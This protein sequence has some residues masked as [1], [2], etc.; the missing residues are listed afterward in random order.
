[1][2]FLRRFI[3]KKSREEAQRSVLPFLS[4]TLS[5][6]TNFK[7]AKYDQLTGTARLPSGET[8]EVEAIGSPSKYTALQV[9]GKVGVVFSDAPIQTHISSSTRKAYVALNVN[10]SIKIRYLGGT[11][12]FDVPVTIPENA[13]EVQ[14]YFSS[15]C[16]HFMVGY[17]E[18][19]NTAPYHSTATYVIFSN[20][21]CNKVSGLFSYTG[22]QQQTYQLNDL[23]NGVLQCPGFGDTF[24]EYIWFNHLPDSGAVGD[25][26]RF[27]PIINSYYDTV[28][29]P[30]EW[31]FYPECPRSFTVTDMAQNGT[32]T[33]SW[34]LDEN[35][36]ADFKSVRFSFNNNASGD[37]V[38]DIVTSF[39]ACT[40]GMMLEQEHTD[41]QDYNSTSSIVY[42][43]DCSKKAGD[44]IYDTTCTNYRKNTFSYSYSYDFIGPD[45]LD[46][47]G[48]DLSA[49]TDIW[50]EGSGTENYVCMDEVYG[51]GSNPG[52]TRSGSTRLYPNILLGNGGTGLPYLEIHT[53]DGFPASNMWYG[54]FY[55]TSWAMPILY[56]PD[57]T[58]Y[59]LT[60]YDGALKSARY[61]GNPE[62]LVSAPAAFAFLR[63]E[64]ILAGL[65]CN[66][67]YHYTLTILGP[68]ARDYYFAMGLMAIRNA[69]GTPTLV[70]DGRPPLMERDYN[71]NISTFLGIDGQTGLVWRQEN[72][73]TDSTY[74]DPADDVSFQAILDI[75]RET[76]DEILIL[77][78]DYLEENIQIPGTVYLN[79][80]SIY[81]VSGSYNADPFYGYDDPYDVATDVVIAPG[82]TFPFENSYLKGLDSYIILG[83]N[84]EGTREVVTVYTVDATG[85]TEVLFKTSKALSYSGGGT[86][87]DVGTKYERT[88]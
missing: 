19:S 39:R 26:V 42:G 55:G 78:A 22:I 53:G 38:V 5:G 20:F 27:F 57:T 51:C 59:F 3:E 71:T 76:G 10:N 7:I 25:F 12:L 74:V 44:L 8:I 13:R 35:T 46:W 68:F 79:T 37:P 40:A 4:R 64:N 65:W 18:R 63:M 86:I 43:F 9:T 77:V 1:M 58:E 41:N 82:G 34:Y 32:Y 30:Y 72:Y 83:Y 29:N 15:N 69:N 45:P 54:Q 47:V 87:L 75:L 6:D 14:A 80:K 17:W 16:K 49:D 33:A 67:Y 23:A 81:W 70:W 61:V 36:L 85:L 73:P 56:P 24:S 66:E 48:T 31:T 52:Y 28:T 50:T 2:S 62:G 84:V 11:T 21:S 88:N 60:T